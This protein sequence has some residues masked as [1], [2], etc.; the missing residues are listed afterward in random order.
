MLFAPLLEDVQELIQQTSN[1]KPVIFAVEFNIV[2]HY[3][4]D[5]NEKKAGSLL[6]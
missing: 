6:Y 4:S 3:K 5:R 1:P 2:M